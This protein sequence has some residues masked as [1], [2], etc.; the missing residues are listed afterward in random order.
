MEIIAQ[1]RQIPLNLAWAITAHKSQGMTLDEA[2]CDLDGA[3]VEGQIYVALSRV[4]S[5]DGLFIETINYNLI[6]AK[7]EALEFYENLNVN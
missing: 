3:F 1:I 6:R 4:K 2:I 7:K 5:L